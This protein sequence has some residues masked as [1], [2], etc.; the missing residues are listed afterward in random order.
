MGIRRCFEKEQMAIAS[1]TMQVI[2]TGGK[3]DND[4]NEDSRST[5]IL[6]EN[7]TSL[8][9]DSRGLLQS[10]TERIQGP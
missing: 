7:K 3:V 8:I 4:E 5:A 9:A 1:M 6:E 10:I 2:L